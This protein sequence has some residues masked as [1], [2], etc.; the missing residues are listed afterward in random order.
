MAFNWRTK[1][2]K[3]ILASLALLLVVGIIIMILVRFNH[4]RQRESIARQVEAQKESQAIAE[5]EAH[6]KLMQPQTD[7]VAKHL[8]GYIFDTNWTESPGSQIEQSMMDTMKVNAEIPDECSLNLTAVDDT[9]SISALAGIVEEVN[10]QVCSINLSRLSP[11]AFSIKPVKSFPTSEIIKWDA[12]ISDNGAVSCEST[13]VY[14]NGDKRVV[15][16]PVVFISFLGREGAK[17]WL[18]DFANMIHANCSS[19]SGSTSAQQA[20]NTSISPT[21]V[22]PQLTQA[23]GERTERNGTLGS[24]GKLTLLG[25]VWGDSPV[26]SAAAL[27]SSGFAKFT[28]PEKRRNAKWTFQCFRRGTDELVTLAIK[29]GIGGQ[30]SYEFSGALYDNVWKALQRQFGNPRAMFDQRDGGWL[31]DFWLDTKQT[32][33]IQITKRID[34]TGEADLGAAD[35]LALQMASKPSLTPTQY[36][37]EIHGNLASFR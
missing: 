34:G 28:C 33:E 7:W 30:V 17:A 27:S 12:N 18:T 3:N 14:G 4:D 36:S 31:D 26:Q 19:Q 6:R 21:N 8:D 10:T 9:K 35:I 1:V 11:R 24:T 20:S 15:Q 22:P 5:A 2:R 13:T 29:D 16:A 37:P 23:S 32:G 25:I